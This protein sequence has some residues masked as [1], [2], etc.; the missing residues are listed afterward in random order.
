METN[1]KIVV[2]EIFNGLELKWG[3]PP[4]NYR[5]AV[6]WRRL[7]FQIQIKAFKI[8]FGLT[9]IIKFDYNG[10]EYPCSLTKWKY[11]GGGNGIYPPLIETSTHYL[12]INTTLHSLTITEEAKA[13]ESEDV[14]LDKNPMM[15]FYLS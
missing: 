11:M 9:R 6:L 12:R 15:V 2:D 3:E 7:Y 4:I 5:I 10:R 14:S 13:S 8:E 1:S